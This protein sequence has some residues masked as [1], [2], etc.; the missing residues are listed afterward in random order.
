MKFEYKNSAKK[1]KGLMIK[2]KKIING[3]M[4]IILPTASVIF[5][6]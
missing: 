5:S 6:P 4:K 1:I 3:V 2:Y